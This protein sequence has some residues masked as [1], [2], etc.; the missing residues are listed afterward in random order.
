MSILR[1]NSYL[2]YRFMFRGQPVYESTGLA[3]T[4]QN[5]KLVQDL[6]AA[7]RQKAS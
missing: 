6:E 5:Q 4:A 1:R 3:D 7:H 2:A